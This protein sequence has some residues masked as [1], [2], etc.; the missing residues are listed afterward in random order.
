V[1]Q[2]ALELEPSPS[3][4]AVVRNSAR[5]PT[6]RIAWL[7]RESVR[8]VLPAQETEQ[9]VRQEQSVQALQQ[10]RIVGRSGPTIDDCVIDRHFRSDREQSRLY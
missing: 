7:A 5:R 4:P 6:A 1:L 2:Q 3:E 10:V 8:I 9:I